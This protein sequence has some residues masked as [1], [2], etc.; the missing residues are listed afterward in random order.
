V[1]SI[2]VISNHNRFRVLFRKIATA[3]YF[4][5]NIYFCFSVGNGQ[6]GEAALCQLY[7]HTFARCDNTAGVSKLKAPGRAG[8]T[9]RCRTAD[10]RR[11]QRDIEL[12]RACRVACLHRRWRNGCLHEPTVGATVGAT[13]RVADIEWPLGPI[14]KLS[15]DLSYDYLKD[16]VERFFLFIWQCKGDYWIRAL[17]PLESD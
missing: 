8:H 12:D 6:P 10:D 11:L 13:G 4:I 16:R 17:L 2:L 15:Y 3:L 7:R 9:S 14:Y 5:W 1:Q